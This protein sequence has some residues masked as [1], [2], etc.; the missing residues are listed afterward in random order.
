MGEEKELKLYQF[1]FS[2]IKFHDDNMS[3]SYYRKPYYLKHLT[4]CR[5]YYENKIN[6]L[7]NKEK[8]LKNKK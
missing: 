1:P 8:V 4:F 7:N 2:V 5:M 6:K 3:L